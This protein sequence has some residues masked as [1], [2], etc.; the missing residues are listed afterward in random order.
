MAQELPRCGGPIEGSGTY[1]RL[2]HANT[3][4]DTCRHPQSRLRVH[5]SVGDWGMPSLALHC[6]GC[7]VSQAL[8][9]VFPGFKRG[10]R[11]DDL[12]VCVGL[13]V[14]VGVWVCGC[15]GVWVCGCVSL[16]INLC[17]PV[18]SGHQIA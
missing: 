12:S 7:I 13:G 16:G 18:T 4:V 6:T 2:T 15:V 3:F 17:M 9:T 5:A 11:V 8:E 10:H 14:C 1:L